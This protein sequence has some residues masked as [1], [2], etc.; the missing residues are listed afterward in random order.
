MGNAGSL[1]LSTTALDLE[2]GR[3]GVWCPWQHL[4]VVSLSAFR[5]RV[6]W[7]R[8]QPI[9]TQSWDRVGRGEVSGSYVMTLM[10]LKF[11]SFS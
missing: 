9:S 1:P 8:S 2:P 5:A 4:L 10:T 6:G 3:K 7:G 11:S